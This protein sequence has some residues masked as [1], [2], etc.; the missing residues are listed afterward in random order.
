MASPRI[1]HNWPELTMSL[2]NGYGRGGRAL[3]VA[4]ILNSERQN[5]EYRNL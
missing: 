5:F 1:T 2:E 3:L 4:I